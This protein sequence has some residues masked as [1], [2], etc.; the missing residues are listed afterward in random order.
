MSAQAQVDI[1]RLPNET[2]EEVLV[3]L[4]RI[5]NDPAVDVVP[6][7]GTGDAGDRTEF[8]HHG[9][10]QEDGKGFRASAPKAE[11]LPYMQRGATDGSYSC[12]KKGMAVY[13]I[14]AFLR[15]ER[16]EPRAR[17]RRAHLPKSLEAGTKLL[18]E[19]VLAGGRGRNRRNPSNCSSSG[20]SGYGCPL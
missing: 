8:A 7:P 10:L 12:G 1:R 18:W 3:R 15:E 11:V 9:A 5:I 13:G 6:A 14:P 17:Q 16:C 2:R 20:D 19:I 4:R